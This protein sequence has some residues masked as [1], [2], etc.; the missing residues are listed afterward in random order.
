MDEEGRAAGIASPGI[1]CE[2]F[3]LP[4]LIGWKGV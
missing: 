1:C 2:H 4:N 3:F